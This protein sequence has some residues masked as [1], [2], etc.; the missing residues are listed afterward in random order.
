M[1]IWVALLGLLLVV[2]VYAAVTHQL[3]TLSER[4]WA[5]TADSPWLRWAGTVG[6]AL[7]ILHFWWGLWD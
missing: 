6:M 1:S 5:R 3:P 4:V 7:L 2:E